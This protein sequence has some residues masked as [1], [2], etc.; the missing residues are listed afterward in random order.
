MKL[1]KSAWMFLLS[2]ILIYTV[3]VSF[4]DNFPLY[5]IIFPILTVLL[6][7]SVPSWDK[8]SNYVY[9]P[10]QVTAICWLLISAW[11]LILSFA[12]GDY[13]IGREYLRFNLGLICAS[14]I[15]SNYMLFDKYDYILKGAYF[16]ISGLIAASGI[17]ES[18]TGNFYHLTRQSYLYYRNS[19]GLYRPNTIFYNINDSA[20][21]MLLSLVIAFL[22]AEQCREKR[23][24]QFLAVIL[25][26]GNIILTESR[27]AE[28]G[29]VVF[30]VVYYLQSKSQTRRTLAVLLVGML[31]VLGML[32][33]YLLSF[34]LLRYTGRSGVWINSLHNLARSYFWGN[35]PG[36]TALLNGI[37]QV[38][39]TSITAVHNFFLEMLCDYGVIGFVLLMIWYVQ[40]LNQAKKQREKYRTSMIVLAGLIAFLPASISSSSLIRKSFVL[41]F[42]A[43]LVAQLNRN[44]RD[45]SANAKIGAAQNEGLP[46]E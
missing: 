26:G 22:F 40:L 30:L 38:Q 5:Q 13:L 23:S 24:V 19:L 15:F 1:F 33:A 44:A 27:G 9:G 20:T 6:L 10:L 32:W 35:G 17:Y 3:K 37:N 28:V 41:A 42:F 46:N 36:K 4:L 18:V 14:V 25:F 11:G 29:M 8:L 2:G 45:E 34:E 21:F 43:Y 31:S 12:N 7:L 16:C 39:S